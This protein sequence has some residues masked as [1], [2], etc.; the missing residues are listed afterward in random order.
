MVCVQGLWARAAITH[1]QKRAPI[2]TAV[3]ID[4]GKPNHIGPLTFIDNQVSRSTG[5]VLLH[6]TFANWMKA[7]RQQWQALSDAPPPHY[8][9]SRCRIAG[10]CT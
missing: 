6:A 2:E 9:P 3:F 1:G 4:G 7:G 8:C 10:T 5:T